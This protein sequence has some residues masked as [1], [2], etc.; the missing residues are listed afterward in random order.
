MNDNR[1]GGQFETADFARK[2]IRLLDMLPRTFGEEL[3]A[4]PAR[5]LLLDLY[6]AARENRE[7][8]MGSACYAARVPATTALRWINSLVDLGLVDRIRSPRD[9]RMIHLRLTPQAEQRVGDSLRLMG[10][11]LMD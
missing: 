1:P 3:F 9:G 4:D 2:V 11:A 6:A 10:R 5:Y 8:T 7:I